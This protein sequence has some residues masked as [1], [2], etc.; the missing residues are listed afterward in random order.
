MNNGKNI[1]EK[2]SGANCVKDKCVIDNYVEDIDLIYDLAELFKVF[3][4][5]T[6]VRILSLL[7]GG[8][9]C[10]LHIADALCMG[11]SAVSHQLRLLRQSGLVRPRREGKTVYYSL[12][13]DHVSRIVSLGIE[14]IRH[15]AGGQK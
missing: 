13:D 1:T 15:K 4:D 5:S 12:D 3:G 2:T 11:Q 9:M 8:E 7:D 6:R 10:V 14:H